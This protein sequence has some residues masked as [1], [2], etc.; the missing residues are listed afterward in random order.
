MVVRNKIKNQRGF[1]LVELMTVVAIIGILASVGVPQYRKIQRKAKRTEASLALGVIA[2]AEA[3]FFAEYVGYGSNMGGIGAE[4][5]NAPKNYNVGFLDSTSGAPYRAENS[6]GTI[7]SVPSQIDFCELNVGCDNDNPSSFPGYTNAAINSPLVESSGSGSAATYTLSTD[8]RV[9]STGFQAIITVS[10][11]SVQ[12]MNATNKLLGGK[13]GT[14]SDIS[15]YT[16]TGFPTTTQSG[17][18]CNT[19]DGCKYRAVAL[20]NLYGRSGN[21]VKLDIMTI[22]H[23]RTVKIEQ[24]GT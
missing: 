3:A 4:L 16:A 22:D 8:N 2:S 12:E 24:E 1:T 5:E 23:Q 11:G 20:G 21:D 18:F 13:S 10:G 9:P 6:S 17:I 14:T 19:D 7:S 15:N